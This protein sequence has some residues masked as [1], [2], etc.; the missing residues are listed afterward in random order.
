MSDLL[1]WRCKPEPCCY[2]G[3]SRPGWVITNHLKAGERS[4]VPRDIVQAELEVGDFSLEIETGRHEGVAY[5]TIWRGPVTRPHNRIVGR[6]SKPVSISPV[7]QAQRAAEAAMRA[8]V[9][10]RRERLTA[11]VARLDELTAAVALM[12]GE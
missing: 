5:W 8:V 3:P 1:C 10:E 4:E 7:E 2:D 9:S 6:G 12:P 11:A